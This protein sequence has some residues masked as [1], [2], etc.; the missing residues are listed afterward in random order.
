MKRQKKKKRKIDL[1]KIYAYIKWKDFYFK[2]WIRLQKA[3]IVDY[4]RIKVYKLN[5]IHVWFKI[6][7]KTVS[8][9]NLFILILHL[10]K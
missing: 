2:N 10:Y 7:K 4:F 6:E 3:N 5:F 9:L 1:E 8:K